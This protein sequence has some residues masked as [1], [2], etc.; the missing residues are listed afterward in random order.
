[1]LVL[2]SLRLTVI[3][4]NGTDC[5]LMLIWTLGQDDH[6]QLSQKINQGQYS[7][8]LLL[9]LLL[10]IL[11]RGVSYLTWHLGLA[12]CIT[13]SCFVKQHYRRTVLCRG[14]AHAK[15]PTNTCNGLLVRTCASLQ[16]TLYYHGIHHDQTICE[17][18]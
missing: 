15:T 12:H 11:Q 13:E 3:I 16:L 17:C 8:L 9:L 7:L 14:T 4:F 18:L 6:A 2:A 1:M 5:Q 10:L